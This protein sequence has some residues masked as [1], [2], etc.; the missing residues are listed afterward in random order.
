MSKRKLSASALVALI[1]LS[2]PMEAFASERT[3]V[4]GLSDFART[5]NSIYSDSTSSYVMTDGQ[6]QEAYR[7]WTYDKIRE[8]MHNRIDLRSTYM[9]EVGL[10]HQNPQDNITTSFAPVEPALPRAAVNARS[11]FTED[12]SSMP[13]GLLMFTADGVAASCSASLVNSSSKKLVLTAAHCLHGG[14]NSTWY[15]SFM[16]TPSAAPHGGQQMF[17]GGTA[18][19]FTDWLEKGGSAGEEANDVGFLSVNTSVLPD[20]LKNLVAIYGG[21][22]FG[23]SNLGSFDATIFGYPKNPGDNRV[24]QSCGA[25][26][27]TVYPLGIGDTLKAEGCSFVDARGSSGGPWL[28][29]YDAS[30]GVGWV[31]S[32]TSTSDVI[33]QQLYGPRFNDRVYKLYTD[34]NND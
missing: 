5:S 26:V 16:F 32:V 4:P 33:A 14:K 27:S 3:D 11:G 19:G 29:L 17:P 10:R 28:Q 21:H 1:V 23:H 6:A 24:P 18:R 7:Y 9:D 22:G 13:T 25:T 2:V 20:S 12:T 15:K 34:S 31:N 30:T 8:A